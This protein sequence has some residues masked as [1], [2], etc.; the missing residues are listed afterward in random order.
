MRENMA[1][2]MQVAKNIS[3]KECHSNSEITCRHFDVITRKL[4][5]MCP[6]FYNE[7]IKQNSEKLRDG[8]VYNDVL[9]CYR[10][11]RSYRELPYM[12]KPSAKKNTKKTLVLDLDETLV[13]SA[14]KPPEKPHVVIPIPVEDKVCKVYVQIRPGA[15]YF[16]EEVSKLYD[17]V[18]FTAS[19]SKYAEPLMK[20]LDP[21]KLCSTYLFREHCSTCSNIFVK[22]LEFLGRDL[23]DVIIIDNSPN[24]YAF[25]PSNALPIPSWYNDISDPG[26]YQ[27]LPLLNKLSLVDDVR[28]YLPLIVSENKVNFK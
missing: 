13:H 15:K 21:N 24:A 6:V 28:M 9:S 26:L 16:L 7:W 1:T 25:H 10:R 3:C 19:V 27:L 4:N 18:I 22:D 12:L 11:L 8:K 17:V 23:K 14:F 2:L 20:E 5:L